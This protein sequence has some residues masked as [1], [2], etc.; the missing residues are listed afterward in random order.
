MGL[1][2]WISLPF[3]VLCW[4][5]KGSPP[6]PANSARCPDNLLA[7]LPSLGLGATY[8][9]SRRYLGIVPLSIS[10]GQTEGQGRDQGGCSTARQVSQSLVLTSPL[11]GNPASHPKSPRP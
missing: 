11:L 1:D 10:E 7:P 5:S 4:T 9:M 3:P 2:H 6:P 8:P